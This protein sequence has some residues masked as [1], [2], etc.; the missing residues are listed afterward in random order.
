MEESLYTYAPHT[1][2]IVETSDKRIKDSTQ[3][4][5][6]KTRSPHMWEAMITILKKDTPAMSSLI[7]IY[8]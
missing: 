5:R 1:L 2:L 4:Y 6:N 7:Y 8:S 3:A